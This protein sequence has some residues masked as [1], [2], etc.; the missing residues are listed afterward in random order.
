MCGTHGDVEIDDALALVVAH[1]D[2]LDPDVG[3]VDG[4]REQEEDGQT[5]DQQ[6]HQHRG[7]HV[8]LTAGRTSRHTHTHTHIVLHLNPELVGCQQ[9]SWQPPA[10][11]AAGAA[12]RQ[13]VTNEEG[14]RVQ[15]G[16]L[17]T[18]PREKREGRR[19]GSGSGDRERERVCV[20]ECAC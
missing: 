7:R 18:E 12:S 2:G 14:H 5:G 20:C 10:G 19:N 3:D 16:A 15:I 4:A 13:A 9:V 17:T 11:A 6:T 8:E 1:V